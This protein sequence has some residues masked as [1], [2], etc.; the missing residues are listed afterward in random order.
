MKQV[1]HISGLRLEVGFLGTRKTSLS[2]IGFTEQT[3]TVGAIENKTY[4]KH[5]NKLK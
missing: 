1:D 3:S 2:E 5:C 4:F